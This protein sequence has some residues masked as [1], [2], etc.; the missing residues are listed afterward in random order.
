MLSHGKHNDKVKVIGA[1]VLPRKFLSIEPFYPRDR[2]LAKYSDF[3]YNELY[4]PP[5]M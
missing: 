3:G 4:V 2:A 1:Q 5:K